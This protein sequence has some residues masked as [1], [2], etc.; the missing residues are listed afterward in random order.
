M[1]YIR[2]REIN[3]EGGGS[4]PTMKTSKFSVTA[5]NR[6]DNSMSTIYDPR[7]NKFS[8]GSDGKLEVKWGK[9]SWIRVNLPRCDPTKMLICKK[10]NRFIF[11]FDDKN[12]RMDYYVDFDSK[13]DFNKLK[14]IYK[15]WGINFGKEKL[16]YP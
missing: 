1:S 7:S 5:N 6:D 8:V 9:K 3:P 14:T 15:Y 11:E 13:S 12:G 16:R 2:G 10:Y 4:P